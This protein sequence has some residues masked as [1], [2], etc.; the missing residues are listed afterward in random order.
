MHT[1]KVYNGKSYTVNRS[2][3]LPITF[4]L[5]S[6]HHPSIFSLFLPPPS[7]YP[8]LFL[9][10]PSLYPLSLPPSTIPLSS[11]SSSLLHPSI[12]SLFLPPP[13]LYPLSLPPSTIPLSPP[14]SSLLHPLSVSSYLPFTPYNI[15]VKDPIVHTNS[16][17]LHDQ[18]LQTSLL[19]AV[20][21]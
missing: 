1:C 20:R 17:A 8:S 2:F 21:G 12:P 5:S 11:P 6:L 7:L 15:L 3:S 9:P 18:H 13:S 19:H 10:P 14:S 4:V 16:T